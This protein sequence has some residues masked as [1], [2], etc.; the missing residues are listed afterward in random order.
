MAFVFRNERIIDNKKN[1]L[2]GPGTFYIYSGT[3]N[4]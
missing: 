2:V 4:F 1:E 3:Y